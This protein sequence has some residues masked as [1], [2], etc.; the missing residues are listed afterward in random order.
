MSLSDDVCSAVFSKKSRLEWS[1]A[2]IKTWLADH[3][4]Q[5]ASPCNLDSFTTFANDWIRRSAGFRQSYA[6]VSSE[7]IRE[8]SLE[9][10]GGEESCRK[11][12][13][14]LD[15]IVMRPKV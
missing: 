1:R 8:A 6:I 10:L 5:S 14:Q 4:M 2:F 11:E 7:D 9:V 13:D 12:I 15:A 3:K